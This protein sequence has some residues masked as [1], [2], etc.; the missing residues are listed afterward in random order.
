MLIRDHLRT[1]N[2]ATAELN[3]IAQVGRA[4]NQRPL[5]RPFGALEYARHA[6]QH[7][8]VHC[9]T[10]EE[11]EGNFILMQMRMMRMTRERL[12]E[13]T[14]SALCASICSLRKRRLD[15]SSRFGKVGNGA[16]RR[17]VAVLRLCILTCLLGRSS[18]PFCLIL[19]AAANN[20]KATSSSS[21]AAPE[22]VRKSLNSQNDE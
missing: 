1:G 2:S 9:R 4:R 15:T 6:R 11:E 10:Q 16:A 13:R 18:A 19:A 3:R 21:A 14:Q 20:N 22:V 5:S 8:L 7:F 17:E 12:L